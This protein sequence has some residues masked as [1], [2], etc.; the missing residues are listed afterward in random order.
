[1]RARHIDQRRAIAVNAERAQ[2]IRNQAIAQI[3]GLGR[4][5]ARRLDM[6]KRRRPIAP[7]RG[8]QALHAPA[9]LIDGDGRV[10]S[11]R[12]AHVCA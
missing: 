5:V 6:G 2:L 3:H 9:L 8:A 10:S 12:I 4:A 7:Y 1:M 11:H